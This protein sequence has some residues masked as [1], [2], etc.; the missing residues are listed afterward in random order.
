MNILLDTHTAIWFITDDQKLPGNCR[1]EI[2]NPG[3]SCFVSIASL[4]EMGIKYS[5]GKLIL[6]TELDKIFEIFFETGFVLLPIKPEHVLVNSNLDFHH[7][8]PFDRIIIAQAIS[9][10]FT[11][12]SGDDSFEK[13]DVKLKWE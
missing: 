7:R 13:Y 12:F 1:E 4:W 6:H 8:D 11:I 3:N 2:S 10:E 9:E 5:I